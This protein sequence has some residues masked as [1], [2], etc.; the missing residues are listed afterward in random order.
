MFDKSFPVLR[1]RPR[2]NLSRNLHDSKITTFSLLLLLLN[3]TLRLSRRHLP[4]AKRRVSS[5]ILTVNKKK[6]VEFAAGA[7]TEQRE[8]KRRGN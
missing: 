5:A 6:D 1:K 4:R 2:Q 3:R 8:K 7:A